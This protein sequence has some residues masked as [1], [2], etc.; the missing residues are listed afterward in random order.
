MKNEALVVRDEDLHRIGYRHEFAHPELA[1]QACT[2][3]AN[4]TW[5]EIVEFSA[6]TLS[7]VITLMLGTIIVGTLVVVTK[8]GIGF[9]LTLPFSWLA[10]RFTM[11][12]GKRLDAW[13][14]KKLVEAGLP[15]LIASDQVF[16][17]TD[18]ALLELERQETID[19]EARLLAA[20]AACREKRDRLDA[21]LMLPPYRRDPSNR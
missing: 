12:I 5:R 4:N 9:L 2:I 21:Q 7:T 16:R 15:N 20:L 13:R 18:T 17:A 10:H 1:E 6:L 3:Y 14:A 8:S 19:S 11:H